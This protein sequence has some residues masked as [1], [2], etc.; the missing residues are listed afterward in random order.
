MKI[1]TET[2]NELAWCYETTCL[3]NGKKYVGQ[4]RLP[5]TSGY[6]GSGTVL[7]IAIKKYGKKNFVRQDLYQGEWEE[8]DLVEQLLIEKVDA[9]NSDEYYNVK[10]GGHSGKHTGQSKKLMAIKAMGRKASLEARAK[11]SKRMSGEG[12]HFFNKKHREKSVLVIKEKRAKQIFS[13]ESNE[14]RS[15][16]IKKLPKDCQCSVCGEWVTR[17]RLMQSHNEKCGNTYSDEQKRIRSEQ[18]KNL[19]RYEC[20]NC[21][22][23]F[24]KRHLLQY[25]NEKCRRD[26]L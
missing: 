13:D 8:I 5:K 22:G 3:V 24:Q 4:S 14:K 2:P 18:I 21:K 17:R 7:K 15:L 9:V 12:N 10:P 19:P 25:H 16:A 26:K 6:V 20:S 11:R 23:L 1:L